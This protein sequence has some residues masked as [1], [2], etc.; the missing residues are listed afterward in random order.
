[1]A[2]QN[3][4]AKALCSLGGDKY[5]KESTENSLQDTFQEARKNVIPFDIHNDK[6][7]LLSDH[8]KGA[9]NLAD[10]FHL[11]EEAYLKALDH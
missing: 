6:W 9:Q 8:H 7:I 2:K 4:I 11:C 1:M 10:D 3:F 5:T